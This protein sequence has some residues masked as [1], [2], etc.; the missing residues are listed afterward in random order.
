MGFPAGFYGLAIPTLLFHLAFTLSY[1]K[2]AMNW[3]LQFSG[4]ADARELDGSSW[5]DFPD[6]NSSSVEPSISPDTI[7]KNLPI[8]TFGKFVERFC[9]SIGDDIKCA[10]CLNSF[11]EEEHIRE[12]CNC[13]HLFHRNCLD[14]WIDHRQT[15]CPL[16]RSSLMPGRILDAEVRKSWIVDR[17]SYIFGEDIAIF[18]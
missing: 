7:R 18:S 17:I 12:L 10:V 15:T 5:P 6:I 2:A 8:V 9:E 13:H 3:A 14:K 4:L 11:Q 1:I 16:C